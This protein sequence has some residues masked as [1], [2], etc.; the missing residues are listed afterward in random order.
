MF[1]DGDIFRWNHH[2]PGEGQICRIKS[3]IGSKFT[4]D[5][6]PYK[7]RQY[8]LSMIRYPTYDEIH[9]IVPQIEFAHL[10]YYAEYLRKFPEYAPK[11]LARKI[12][13]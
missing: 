4:I 6:D 10:H 12:D 2:G 8:D 9:G 5:D 13:K 1:K 11:K 7:D 3:V